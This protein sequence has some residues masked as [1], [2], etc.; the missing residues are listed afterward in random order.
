MKIFQSSTRIVLL[1]FSLVSAVALFLNKITSENRMVLNS[2]VFTFF[3]TKK[4]ENT[5]M[6]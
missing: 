2:M 6:Q 3:F 4:W 5:S 1:L